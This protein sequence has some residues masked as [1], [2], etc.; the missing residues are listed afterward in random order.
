MTMRHWLRMNE[1]LKDD[2]NPD[3]EDYIGRADLLITRNW[4]GHEI[5][6]MLRHSLRDGSRSHGAAELDWSFPIRGGLSGYLQLFHGYGES[7][8][9]Y[10][11]SAT[12]V[13]LG[14]SL[15][16]WYEPAQGQ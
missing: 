14:V 10:N 7:L 6:A 15:V 2:D 9:D 3:I 16:N 8:I 1:E 4:N 13:G 5:S 11:H 12:F